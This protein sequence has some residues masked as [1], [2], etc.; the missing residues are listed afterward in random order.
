MRAAFYESDIT[1]PLGCYQTGYGFERYAED[2]YNK[3]YSKALVLE[4]GGNYAVIIAVDICEYPE[5]LHDRVTKRIE[6]YTGISPDCVCVHSTHTHWGAPV[7]DNPD[8][9]CYSDESYTDVF[10]RLVA[11]SAIL[12]YKRLDECKIYYGSVKVP[13]IAYNRCSVLKDGTLRTFVTNP[14]IIDRPLSEPDHE[15]SVLYIEKQGKKIGAL[16]S[17]GCHQDTVVKKDTYG[18]SGDYSSVISDC[19]KNEYGMDFIS[20][21]LAAP[22]GDINHINSTQKNYDSQCKSWTEIGKIL[23]SGIKE[24]FC[25]SKDVGNGIFAVK[26]S[27]DIPIRKYS[28]EEFKK[29]AKIYLEQDKGCGFRL[30]NLVYYQKVQK[31]DF[32]KLYIQIIKVGNLAIFIYP[33]EMFKIYGIR[34]KENSKFEHTMVIE[35][36][37]SCGGYIA[38]PEAYSEKSFLYETSPAYD[39]FVVADGGG[40]LYDQML[41]IAD[42]IN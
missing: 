41:E 21:Y 25:N 1:P 27:V 15:L 9:N 19:L 8:I 11:D 7:T 12:A 18:Y 42:L 16:Y 5:E 38:P 17:F 34:T 2:V 23:F 6:E 30:S 39:S 14:D 4:D 24:A 37:N 26:K 28:D 29:L 20:I 10:Y 33:G 3:L 36:S 31:K 40:I 13:G 32:A 22:S 35:N